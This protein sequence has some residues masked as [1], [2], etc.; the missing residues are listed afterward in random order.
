MVELVIAVMIISVVV[1]YMALNFPK[2]SAN[3]ANNRHHWL[4]V[5]FAAQRIQELKAQTYPMVQPTLATP[6][7][8][9]VS[10][11][12]AF[13]IAGY[14]QSCNCD[15]ED[16]SN[17]AAFLDSTYSED[18]V[19]YTR[20]VCIHLVDHQGGNWTSYCPDNTNNTDK[21][22]KHIRVRVIW[23]TG[24]NPGAP[25]Y[26]TDAESLVSRQ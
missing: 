2:A 11:I 7:N 23:S 22:L 17:P 25:Q 16:L 1:V 19:T 4:A 6:G 12:T 3:V 20:K 8:F 13:P 9:P 18:G 14:D 21:G 10:S 24:G 15:V 26:F 5:N